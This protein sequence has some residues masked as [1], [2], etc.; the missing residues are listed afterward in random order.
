MY[1]ITFI[2]YVITFI[3]YVLTFIRYV[4]TFI[5]YVIIFI[6][7]VI[8]F[9]RY[10]I[11]FIRFVITFI[12]Y[13]ITFIRY[14][15]TFIRYVITFIRYVIT[16]IRFAFGII[17]STI[18]DLCHDNELYS[19]LNL[20]YQEK[21]TTDVSSM[22]CHTRELNPLTTIS[23][24]KNSFLLVNDICICQENDID[25]KY[26]KAVSFPT[27]HKVLFYMNANKTNFIVTIKWY[28]HLQYRIG[29]LHLHGSSARK[30]Q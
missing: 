29:F 14:V 1:V 18:C 19:R 28:R 10:V 20:N 11:P 17:L 15:I 8:T 24:F 13:V 22:P 7:F 12:R 4:I 23:M 30:N 6:R 9:I 3:M 27:F 25:K 16:F 26:L 2:R 21:I 5:T